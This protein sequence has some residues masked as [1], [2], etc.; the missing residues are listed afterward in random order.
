MDNTAVPGTPDIAAERLRRQRLLRT[1]LGDPVSVVGW[2]GAVQ[3]QEYPAARWGL[4]LRGAGFTD[5]DVE[6]AFDRGAILR[7]HVLRPT[8]HFVTPADIRWMLA[9]TGPRVQATMA[10]YHRTR[11][12]DAALL[13]KSRKVIER[14]LRGGQTRTRKEIAGALRLAGIDVKTLRL[15]FVVIDAELEGVI[16]SGPRRGK[17]FTY[18]LLEERVPPAPVLKGDEALAELTRRYYTSHGPATIRDLAW[19]SGLT[20]GSI[21]RGIEILGSRLTKITAQDLTCWCCEPPRSR[22]TTKPSAHLL[23]IYDEFLIAYKDRVFMKRNA[24]T[25]KLH[26]GPD[27]FAH[28][29]VIDGRLAGS[30][31]PAEKNGLVSVSIALYDRATG[32]EREAIHAAVEKYGRFLGK[33]INL[34]GL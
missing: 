25:P 13:A 26:I 20:Q 4:G 23:P 30:W 27:V 2:L 33:P 9:L 17:E 1:T 34:L 16:C 10:T 19:W 12:I 28:Y 15:V 32:S 24:K 14:T 29:L 6:A 11:E 22:T 31:E 3:A 8:W 18:A 21:R 7:T 5:A